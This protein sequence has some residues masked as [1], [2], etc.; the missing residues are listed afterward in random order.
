MKRNSA[1]PAITEFRVIDWLAFVVAAVSGFLAPAITPVAL[2]V[3]WFI[4]IRHAAT[5]D[6]V[7]VG[8][9]MTSAS[10]LI[11]LVALIPA[12]GAVAA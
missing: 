5:K 2:V 11:W 1:R 4:L 6:R 10:L 7:V 12:Y 9:L 3:A 8:A